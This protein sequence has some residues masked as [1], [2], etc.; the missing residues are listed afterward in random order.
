MIFC[1]EHCS[2]RERAAQCHL[3][4]ALSHGFAIRP[5][6][7]IAIV[8][9]A[10][11]FGSAATTHAKPTGLSGFQVVRVTVSDPSELVTLRALEAADR[12]VEIWTDGAGYGAA[13]VRIPPAQKR[14]LDAAGLEY[15]VVIEDLQATYDELFSAGEGAGFFDAYR[16]YDEHVAFMIDLAQTY[17]DLATMVN[18]GQSHE[19]RILWALHIAGQ[20]GEMPAVLY[21]GAQHGNEVLGACVVAYLAQQ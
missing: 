1:V 15:E 8:G 4:S 11:L 21:H 13:D 16:S 6:Y 12:D 18:L 9:M 7:Q 3:S 2:G 5:L 17:P 19:G 20:G 14:A 10:L